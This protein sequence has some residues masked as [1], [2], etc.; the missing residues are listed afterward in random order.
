ML[1]KQK[2]VRMSERF[3]LQL[4]RTSGTTVPSSDNM[5]DGEIA[6]STDNDEPK[7]FLKKNN[8]EIAEFIDRKVI[9]EIAITSDSIIRTE[10]EFDAVTTTGKVVDAKIVHDVIKDDEE[11]TS[12]ALNNLNSRVDMISGKTETDPTVPQHVKDIS[13]ADISSWNGKADMADITTAVA[14]ESGRSENTYSKKNDVQNLSSSTV[15]IESNVSSLSGSA[16]GIV[17]SLSELS[18]STK[19]IEGQVSTLSSTAIT[20]ITGQSGVTATKTGVVV[21]VSLSASITGSTTGTSIVNIS[22]SNHLAYE[23]ISANATLSFNGTISN[24]NEVHVIIKN[25]SSS[26][27]ITVTLPSGGNYIQTANDVIYISA[28]KYGE[29]NACA[30]GGKTYVRGIDSI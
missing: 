7:L 23:E 24:G 29:V 21:T 18:S 1:N 14:A 15:R 8:G 22:S 4:Y 13:Q 11:I 10:E 12:A 25:T 3:I 19:N 20:G 27:T 9:S 26:G 16:V 5:H 17:N 6:V 30:I 2:C 28:G